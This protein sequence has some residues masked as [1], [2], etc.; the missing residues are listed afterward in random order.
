MRTKRWVAILGAIGVAAGMQAC[1]TGGTTVR[2]VAGDAAADVGS[3]A[4]DLPRDAPADGPAE[5]RFDA[6]P[7]VPDAPPDVA[8]DVAPD[9]PTDAPT[10]APGDV[11]SAWPVLT[12]MSFNLRTAFGDTD[13]NAWENRRDLCAQVIREEGAVLVGTQ[14]GWLFQLD[15]LVARL[16]GFAWVGRSRTDTD[17][18]E[19]SALLYRE[20]LFEVVDT[21]TIA[22]SDTPGTI[23]TTFSPAQA[24]P[25]ILTWARLRDRASGRVLAAFNTHFDYVATDDIQVRMAALAARTVAEVAGD[26]P[27]VLTGDFNAGPGGA[28]WRVLT[29][30]DEYDGVRGDL[31]DAFVELAVP[32]EGTFH[33][34]T[35]VATDARI[36]WILHDPAHLRATAAAI[37]KTRDGDRWP[38]DHFPVRADLQAPSDPVPAPAGGRP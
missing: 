22:L 32:E 26:D 9:A 3:D 14:E 6:G 11:P 37:V 38:S 4:A 12:V 5:A 7:D 34:F 16:P 21:D 23:G 29:G 18:D 25:R 19:F 36:D 31:V 30:Q 20:D 1:G 17:F 2:D 13:A 27:A 10:D 33:G 28:P 15:D 24:Y 35:G 8:P